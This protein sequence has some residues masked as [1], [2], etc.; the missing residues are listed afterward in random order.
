M[1][2]QAFEQGYAKPRRPLGVRRLKRNQRDTRTPAKPCKTTRVHVQDLCQ[3][4]SGARFSKGGN[5]RARLLTG[6]FI[7][8]EV[9]FLEAPVNFPST[10]RGTEKIA[11]RYQ[12]LAQSLHCRPREKR[13]RFHSKDN[14]IRSKFNFEIIFM[15][16]HIIPKR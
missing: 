14:A 4:R 12:T 16:Y 1:H 7:G 10:Y 8:P 13:K 6:S 2:P 5:L 9:V 3:S 15:H 11:G